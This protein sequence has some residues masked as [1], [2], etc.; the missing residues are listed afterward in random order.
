MDF[1]QAFVAYPQT[2]HPMQPGKRALHHPGT[3]QTA[4]RYACPIK[5]RGTHSQLRPGEPV[6]EEYAEMERA[7]FSSVVVGPYASNA[8]AV[9]TETTDLNTMLDIMARHGVIRG[10]YKG[11]L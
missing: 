10:V 8:I 5:P 11:W 2:P 9:V 3:L 4:T 1:R 7:M 6:P